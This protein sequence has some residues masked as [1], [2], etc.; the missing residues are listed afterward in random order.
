MLAPGVVPNPK[1][2]RIR[3]DTPLARQSGVKTAF[4]DTNISY[5]K[6][7]GQG[8]MPIADWIV[9]KQTKETKTPT[10]NF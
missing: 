6:G 9:Q 10:M 4:L 7:E 8:E 2:R 1:T 3:N 5:C